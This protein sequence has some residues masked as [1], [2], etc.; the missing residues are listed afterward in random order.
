[1]EKRGLLYEGKAK[2][3]YATDDPDRV[4]MFY[5]DD[6]TA[7][8]GVKKSSIS[9]KGVLNN[10]ISTVIFNLLENQG[11]PTHLVETINDREQLC[12]KVD[13]IPLE[14]I[15]RNTIAGSMAN[16]LGIDEGTVPSNTI[17]EL[18]YK[19]DDY[20]DPLINEDHAVALNLATYEELAEV[21]SMALQINSVLKEFFAGLGL[22]L[23]DFKVEFGR[24]PDGRIV[25]A[26]EFSPDSCRLWDS[27]TG[28]KMDKDRF[29]RDL[30]NVQEAYAE[31]LKRVT[32]G[33]VKQKPAQEQ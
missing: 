17:Y 31:V 30:G 4:I 5:K 12:E 3:I 11:I 6:A 29:R 22:N 16:R 9:N 19:N 32:D 2:R 7:F 25:L 24:T 14:V 21:K 20:G 13:I 15:V 28:A 27:A 10:G 8:N 1:M 18:S 26:D 33:S 23:V